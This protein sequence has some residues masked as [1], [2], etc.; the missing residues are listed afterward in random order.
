MNPHKARSNDLPG[1]PRL[2]ALVNITSAFFSFCFSNLEWAMGIQCGQMSI[3]I[4]MP[5][6][7]VISA[8]GKKDD[9]VPHPMSKTFAPLKILACVTNLAPK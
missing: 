3:P 2:R 5:S 1:K 8:A 4:T 6:D 9:P 7:P